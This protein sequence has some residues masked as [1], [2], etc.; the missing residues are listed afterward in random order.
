M[1]DG[2]RRI[3]A[4]AWAVVGWALTT[5]VIR[6]VGL[7]DEDFESWPVCAVV[8]AAAL[9]TGELPDRWHRRRRRARER[10]SPGSGAPRE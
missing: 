10:R 3:K 6:F 2:G 9:A 7:V 4:V 5:V 1:T 8:A